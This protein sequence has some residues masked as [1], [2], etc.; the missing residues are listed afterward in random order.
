MFSGVTE[1]E[2]W[3]KMDFKNLRFLKALT[4]LICRV[5]MLEVLNEI[6][7]HKQ[8]KSCLSRTLNVLQPQFIFDLK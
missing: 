4:F 3:F 7:T 1:V 6:L 5:V 2:H 8:K